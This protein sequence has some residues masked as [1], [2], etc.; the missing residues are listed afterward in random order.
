MRVSG[1]NLCLG[2]PGPFVLHFRLHQ[3]VPR[4]GAPVQGCL[5]VEA[6]Q[7]LAVSA[8]TPEEQRVFHFSSQKQEGKKTID[9]FQDPQR[10]VFF[11]LMFLLHKTKQ[12]SIPFKGLVQLFRVSKTR[13]SD[14]WGGTTSPASGSFNAWNRCP[15]LLRDSKP[16]FLFKIR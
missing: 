4:G 11:C 12:K 1:I 6:L 7:S 9:M 8:K 13:S 3:E 5:S 10:N 14:A 16:W 15:G 2:G